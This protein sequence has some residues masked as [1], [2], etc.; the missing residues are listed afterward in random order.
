MMSHD[1]H[2]RQAAPAAPAGPQSERSLRLTIRL[3]LVTG[4]GTGY[5]PF[6]SGSWG[7]LAAVGVALACWGMVWGSGINA[8]WLNLVWVVLTVLA[9]IGCVRWGPWAINYFAA[10]AK[11]PGDPGMVVLDEF[12]GQWLALLALPMYTLNQAL[13]VLAV[14]FFLFRLFDVI[15]PS[16]ARRAERLPHGWG[17]LTDDLVAALYA[18]LI[19]QVVF[20]VLL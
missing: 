19:G 16:P 6:A 1:L 13:A 20:R 15:K 14:Q 17:I 8:G 5:M 11:K 7:S 12:A 18:N 4:F 9:C 10:R 3:W 2:P